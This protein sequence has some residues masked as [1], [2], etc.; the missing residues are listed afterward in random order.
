MKIGI[1][2]GKQLLQLLHDKCLRS[3]CRPPPLSL[4]ANRDG[5]NWPPQALVRHTHS[6]HMRTAEVLVEFGAKVAIC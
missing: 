1:V 4:A 6:K 2:P 3:L 5:W